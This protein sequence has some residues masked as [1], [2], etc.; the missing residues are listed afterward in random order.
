MDY[1]FIEGI[2]R[3]DVAFRV[4]GRDPAELFTAGA[5]AVISI[6]LQNPETVRP[7]KE[8]IIECESP[9]L[10]LLYYD[11]LS[12]FIFY[13]DSG[14]LLLVPDTVDIEAVQGGYRLSCRARG[15][16]IDRN[17]HI[18]KVDIKAITLHHL[19]ISNEHDAWQA[20]AVADV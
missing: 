5:R 1:E 18:F 12:E 4:R 9:E 6:M 16:S 20:T 14:R 10:D 3:A 11:F 2:S 15:E 13:K 7:E 19:R 8:I 17:R